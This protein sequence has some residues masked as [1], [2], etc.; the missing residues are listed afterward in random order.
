V[1]NRNFQKTILKDKNFALLTQNIG[2]EV[3][4]F[5]PDPRQAAETLGLCADHR[6][7]R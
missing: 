7:R 2:I 5:S 1:N 6:L 4:R 3:K